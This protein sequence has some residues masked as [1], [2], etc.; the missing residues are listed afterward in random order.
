MPRRNSDTGACPSSEPSF[1]SS[2]AAILGH[3]SRACGILQRRSAFPAEDHR[4]VRALEARNAE[5]RPPDRAHAELE[6]RPFAAPDEP[7]L[8]RGEADV[9]RGFVAGA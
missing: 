4:Q 3:R 6:G 2:M 1:T 8:A 7:Q 5:E 9:V